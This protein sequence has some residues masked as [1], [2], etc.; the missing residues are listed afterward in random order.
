MQN[1]VN[2]KARRERGR[3]GG[4]RRGRIGGK[5]K[6]NEIHII[7]WIISPRDT[8]FT[9]GKLRPKGAMKFSQGYVASQ[10]KS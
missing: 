10:W 9:L 7:Q 8:H 5:E 4:R 1:K 6:R 3:E 2:Q